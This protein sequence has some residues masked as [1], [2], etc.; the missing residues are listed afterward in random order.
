MQ[1]PD[2]HTDQQDAGNRPSREL[3]NPEFTDPEAESQR[4]KDSKLRVMPEQIGKPFHI[5]IFFGVNKIDNETRQRK[6]LL[7]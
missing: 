4:E 1:L 2:Q 6:E 3:F 5:S 7:C